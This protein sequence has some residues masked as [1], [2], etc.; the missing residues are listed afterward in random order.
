MKTRLQKML[1]P[2]VVASLFFFFPAPDGL[3]LPAWHLFGIFAGTI[4]ALIFQ[5]YPESTMLIIAVTLASIF[6]PLHEILIG[7]A[8]GMLWLTVVAIMISMGL[9]KSGLTRRIGLILISKFG[10]T[11]LRIGYIISFIDLLLATSTPASPARTGGLVYPLVEGV[12][13]TC[14]CTSALNQR[15]LAGYFTLLAYMIS[16]T[17]GSLFMT[18]MGPNLIN[19]KLASD[20]LGISVSWPLWVIGALPGFIVFLL[21]PYVI[22]IIYKPGPVSMN[23]VRERAFIELK[24]LEDLAVMS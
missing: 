24:A 20:V 11:L 8:D 10:K 6:V 1:I 15:K 14:N 2:V 7:Y 3:N 21:I 16:M 19:V 12:I 23:E 22:Y 9:K 18:G 17:T 5:P 13:D 4:F